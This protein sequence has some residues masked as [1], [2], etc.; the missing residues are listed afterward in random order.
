MKPYKFT[1]VFEPEKDQKDVYNV[2]V[3]ALSGC[4]TFGESL[5]EARYNIR[6]AIE[7]YL[8]CLLEEE[9]SI[10]KDKKVMVPR[11]AIIEEII[12]GVDF[13]VKAGFTPERKLAYV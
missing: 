6:E 10:P 13:D 2:Y 12:V 1:V 4:H 11:K 8:E 5:A 3:P 9:R 7:L